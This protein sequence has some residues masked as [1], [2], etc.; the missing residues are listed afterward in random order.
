M[1]TLRKSRKTFLSSSTNCRLND[2]RTKRS[3]GLL[4]KRYPKTKKER[5]MENQTLSNLHVYLYVET[6][7]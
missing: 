5:T 7:Y 6:S 4:A 2:A 1:P 3:F